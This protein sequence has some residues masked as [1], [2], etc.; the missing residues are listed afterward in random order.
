M[1]SLRLRPAATERGRMPVKAALG[2]GP[3]RISTS[4]RGPRSPKVQGLSNPDGP[5]NQLT[6]ASI[7]GSPPCRPCQTKRWAA[8]RPKGDP[9]NRRFDGHRGDAGLVQRAGR[10]PAMTFPF[11]CMWTGTK[12]EAT[13]GNTL[14]C[15]VSL[16]VGDVATIA[17]L[18]PQSPRGKAQDGC[19]TMPCQLAGRASIAGQGEPAP[20]ALRQRTRVWGKRM[21]G[22]VVEMPKKRWHRPPGERNELPETAFPSRKWT[23]SSGKA[24]KANRSQRRKPPPRGSHGSASPRGHGDAGLRCAAWLFYGAVAVASLNSRIH[25]SASSLPYEPAMT[26]LGFVLLSGWPISDSKR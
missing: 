20:E 5:M 21:L 19:R 8:T 4:Q 6:M 9:P 16:D 25:R 1:P 14:R 10:R 3:P 24:S 12:S 7:T 26:S 15:R 23:C 2:E 11:H 13:Q 17:A 18:W 22:N